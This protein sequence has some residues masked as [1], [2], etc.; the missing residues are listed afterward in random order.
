MVGL[1]GGAGVLGTPAGESGGLGGTYPVRGASGG[2]GAFVVDRVGLR[3]ALG[4]TRLDFARALVALAFG[5]PSAPFPAIIA[6]IVR[7]PA[8]N[9]PSLSLPPG[10]PPNAGVPPGGVWPTGGAEP[11]LLPYSSSL[12]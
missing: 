6:G 12:R 3:G 2:L 5:I 10:G 8:C 4:G 1:G 9:Q 11:A 7:P